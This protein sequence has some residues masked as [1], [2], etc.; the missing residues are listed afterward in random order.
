MDEWTRKCTWR[1]C[2]ACTQCAEDSPTAFS[3]LLPLGVIVGLLV[4]LFVGLVVARH[5]ANGRTAPPTTGPLNVPPT[6]PGSS[7]AT[8]IN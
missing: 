5:G 3:F 7:A 4:V 6:V 8:D 1:D 2:G